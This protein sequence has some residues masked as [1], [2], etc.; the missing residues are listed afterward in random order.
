MT[1]IVANGKIL[2]ADTRQS[3][4]ISR[5]TLRSEKVNKL[6]PVCISLGHSFDF[7]NSKFSGMEDTLVAVGVA[8]TAAVHEVLV[9]HFKSTEDKPNPTTIKDLALFHSG[10]AIG[11]SSSICGITA[12][13]RTILLISDTGAIGSNIYWY[14]SGVVVGIG[15][16]YSY[17]RDL[18]TKLNRNAPNDLDMQ[19]FLGSVL[20]DCSSISYHQYANETGKISKL[21]KPSKA[22]AA[23][24]A[25]KLLEHFTNHRCIKKDMCDLK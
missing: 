5:E 13:G 16:G 14:S 15:S 4:S 22:E 6:C 2:R 24:H 10:A 3:A 8:G 19:F 17:V 1:N 12:K 20:D 11:G 21:I 18:E 9:R 25:K 7:A 23:R